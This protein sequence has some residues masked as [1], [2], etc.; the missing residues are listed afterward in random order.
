MKL[1]YIPSRST[2]HSPRMAEQAEVGQIENRNASPMSRRK[3]C[4]NVASPIV[5]LPY[6]T[7]NA[8]LSEAGELRFELVFA[9]TD[10][11][12]VTLGLR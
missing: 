2:S 8:G 1:R 7:G 9:I 10:G 4:Q 5:V 12:E 3:C 11:I 6:L